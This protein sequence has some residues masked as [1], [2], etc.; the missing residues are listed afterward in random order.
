M[1]LLC[2]DISSTGISAALF[3]SKLEPIQLGER[4]W[5]PG[6]TLDLHKIVA[7]FKESIAGLKPESV[8]AICI[9]TFMHNIVLL[10]AND[11][12]LTPVFTW[13]DSR[14]ESGVESVRNRL[15]D[16]FHQR[17]GCRYHPMFP[18]FKLASLDV[19]G[20]A[21][22]VSLKSFLLHAL[23]R[24]VERGSRNCARVRALQHSRRA[25]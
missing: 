9:G 5:A 6:A 4:R 15:G 24:R 14:G 12:A 21:R 3:D 20:S 2:F 23:T 11:N 13:L 18:V 17:T 7:H 25:L 19:S 8:D 22:A 1:T 16:T 10:D